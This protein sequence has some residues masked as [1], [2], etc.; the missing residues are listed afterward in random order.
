MS[1]QPNKLHEPD[2][3]PLLVP[4]VVTLEQVQ[5]A[6]GGLGISRET[7]GRLTEVVITPD[8]ITYELRLGESWQRVAVETLIGKPDRFAVE[9]RV[10]SAEIRWAS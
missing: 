7:V 4:H 10:A 9:L 8:R 1:G 5:R 2:L 6:I 3:A